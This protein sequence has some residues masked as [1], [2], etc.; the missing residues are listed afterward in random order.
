MEVVAL[1]RVRRSNPEQSIAPGESIHI[2]VAASPVGLF[3]M[4]SSDI[5]GL[6]F[7][8]LCLT[9]I[10]TPPPPIPVQNV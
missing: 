7:I 2:N 9:A 10:A 1:E 3:G 4:A 6:E 5:C 8:L